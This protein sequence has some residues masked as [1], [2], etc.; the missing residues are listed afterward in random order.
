MNAHPEGEAHRNPFRAVIKDV[1]ILNCG[2][3][4][5]RRLTR[6]AFAFCGASEV[7][8]KKKAMPEG[9]AKFR[10]ETSKKQTARLVVALLRCTT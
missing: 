8:D 10:E 2:R 6:Q 4:P 5:E 7:L 3:R 9:I 1:G